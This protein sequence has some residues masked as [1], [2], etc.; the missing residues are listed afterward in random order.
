M[1]T[2]IEGD[3]LRDAVVDLSV[4]AR[5]VFLSMHRIAG[6]KE[7]WKCLGDE[8]DEAID[9]LRDYRAPLRCEPPEGTENLTWH[10]LRGPM[11]MPFSAFWRNGAWAVFEEDGDI[12]P[13][14]AGAHKWTY[15][16]AN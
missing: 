6:A 16:C 12:S 15:W 8:L 1:T 3:R 11:S 13:R 14:Q 4:R 5:E 9:A 7:A 10:W 2:D